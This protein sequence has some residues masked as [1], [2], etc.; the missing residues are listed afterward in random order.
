MYQKRYGD[1]SALT[2]FHEEIQQLAEN[3][4]TIANPTFC[5]GLAG[6]NWFFRFLNQQEAVLDDDDTASICNRDAMLE[7]ASLTFL[8]AGNYDF[9]HGGLGIAYYLLYQNPA[10][11]QNYFSQVFQ[12]L[13]LQLIGQDQG[14]ALAAYDFAGK[15]VVL[16]DVN[17][18]LAHGVPSIL[19]FCIQC[20][21][22]GICVDESRYIANK[23]SSYLVYQG[24]LQ[25]TFPSMVKNNR[26]G[27]MPDSRLAWCYGDIGTGFT[28]YQAALVLNDFKLKMFAED[29]LE[30]SCRRRLPK[31]TGVMDA[32]ICHGSAGIAHVYN[33]M[34]FYTKKEV[35]KSAA[36]Y[37]LD[38]TLDFR[39]F[40]KG[41]AGYM[42][43]RF[44]TAPR[45]ENVY[46]LLGGAAGIGLV[47]LSYLTGDFSW[48]YCLLLND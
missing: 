1:L 45:Y 25:G 28:L 46:G 27:A 13:K 26:Y 31:D 35:F 6:V 9:L 39:V 15:K 10:E 3:S 32:C 5:N 29:I 44:D 41:V 43:Y 22:M 16:E 40:E 18:G 14:S 2:E 48:D 30:R 19:K 23:I 34:W 17:L 38:V 47:L 33:K 20:I 12:I 24:S 21:S 42:M 8:N 37:W 7:E 11:R 4:F 36:E